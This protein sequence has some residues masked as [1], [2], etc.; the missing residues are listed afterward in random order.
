MRSRSRSPW[1]SDGLP[2]R[3]TS[4]RWSSSPVTTRYGMARPASVRT[5]W[6]TPSR[7]ACS[8]RCWPVRRRCGPLVRTWRWRCW[9]RT[10]RR[11]APWSS[12]SPS[13][14]PR[15]TVARSCPTSQEP[16]PRCSRRRR[17]CH[18]RSAVRAPFPSGARGVRRGRAHRRATGPA[19]PRRG[20]RGRPLARADA[21]C[22]TAHGLLLPRS[23][24][25]GSQRYVTCCRR[26]VRSY[27]PA[28][29][30]GTLLLDDGMSSLDATRRAAVL[31]LLRAGQRVSACDRT[32]ARRDSRLAVDP[33][34]SPSGQPGRSRGVRW[35]SA[36]WAGARSAP[37]FSVVAFLGALRL[38]AGLLER[39][40]LLRGALA[41]AAGAR[42]SSSPGGLGPSLLRRRRPAG[43]RL[44]RCLLARPGPPS[45]PSSCGG[46]AAAAL[47][48]AVI[49][50]EPSWP[51][52]LAPGRRLES[53]PGRNFGTVVCLT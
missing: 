2:R 12:A 35:R 43:N 31:R 22:R 27:D 47:R 50:P 45:W 6:A 3:R 11:C 19:A 28:T 14:A 5:S 10:C 46:A 7:A 24:T 23:S 21:R 49:C 37:A 39:G 17:V 26:T 40:G 41:G 51:R 34:P 15:P 20:H 42:W 13:T 38:A 18:L 16:G 9:P 53:T 32:P 1:T 8:P 52:F 25:P 36:L 44:L 48:A 4:A 29:R 33:G 30:S